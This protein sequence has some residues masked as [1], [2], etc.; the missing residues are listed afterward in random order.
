MVLSFSHRSICSVWIPRSLFFCGDDIEYGLRIK[1]N[2]LFLN[3]IC[4]WHPCFEN[5][6]SPLREYLSLR[7]YAL[8]CKS[9]LKSWRYELI[10]FFFRKIARCIAANDYELG[11]ITILAIRDFLEFTN[12]HRSGSLLISRIE[13]VRLRWSNKKEIT[14]YHPLKI[15][16]KTLRYNILPMLFV[17]LT[18]GGILVPSFLRRRYT[19]AP[20]LQ[21]GGRWA[22]QLTAYKENQGYAFKFQGKFAFLLIVKFFIHVFLIVKSYYK[23]KF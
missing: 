16:E 2:P 14:H 7:N 11:A 8:R 20:F 3:G 19:I 13:A 5:K 22:S 21:V 10:K 23:I 9:H 17:F 12:T 6:N 18:F 1:K 4:I 15:K